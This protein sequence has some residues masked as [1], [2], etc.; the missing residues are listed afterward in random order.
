MRPQGAFTR[1]GRGG[2]RAVGVAA[3]LAR[4]FG[5]LL[6]ALLLAPAGARADALDGVLAVRSAYVSVDGGVFGLHARIDYPVN[7]EIRA[8]L[9]DG[10]TLL[11]DVDVDV[12]RER[13][14]WFDAGIVQLRLRRELAFHTVSDRYVVRDSRSG[15]QQSFQTLEAALE[16]IGTVDALP[17][18]VEP[19]LDADARYRVSVRAGVRRGRLPDALRVIMF[20]ADDWHRESEWYAWSLPR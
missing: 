11:F 10:V 4:L 1:R 13:R 18:L 17:I 3:G 14:F 8:A 9:K 19:Q 5:C 7:E 20:W 15:E 12:S 16:H 2:P 6:A